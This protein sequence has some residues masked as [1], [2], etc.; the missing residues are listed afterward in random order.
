MTN[1]R[2]RKAL[3][4]KLGITPQ[5]LSQQVQRLKREHPMT[6]EDATYLIAHRKGLMLD[7]FLDNTTIDRIRALVSDS[8]GN[9]PMR[10]SSDR[11]RRK[12]STEVPKI[13]IG[14]SGKSYND[15]LL[16]GAKLKEAMAMAD[17]FPL[18][19]LLENSIRCFID[20][21]M[22]ATHGKDWWNSYS[23]SRLK[24]DVRRRMADEERHAWHQRRGARPIDYL[25][26]DDLPALMRKIESAV[27][28]RFIPSLRW[29]E[30]FVEEVYQSR[31]VICHMNPID[32]DNKKGLEL[33]FRQWEKL[34][35]AK[36]DDLEGL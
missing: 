9:G 1:Q 4:Q 3:L 16:T 31:C 15:P 22:S 35:A 26:L 24:K 28:P 18:L 23:P 29:F 27:V 14:S 13:V 8:S 25:D 6:T 21:V 7:R 17:L 36:R 20:K 10:T 2:L 19:F 33:R 30:Q 5:A 34:M 11:T 12:Q 32:G